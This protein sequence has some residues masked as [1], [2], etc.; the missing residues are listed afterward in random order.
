MMEHGLIILVLI[1]T[2]Y[3]GLK[4]RPWKQEFYLAGR[5]A[6]SVQ[7]A[8]SLL[9]TSLGG[10]AVFG[11][12]GK[13]SEIGWAAFWWLGGGAAGLLLLGLL[14]TTSMRRRPDNITLPQWLAAGYGEPAR[15]LS[16]VLIAIMWIGVV[17]AQWIAA[18]TLLNSLAG[19]PMAL[20]I[21]IMAFT[22]VIYTSAGGQSSVLRTDIL[23][24]LAIFGSL[25]LTAVFIIFQERL[26]ELIELFRVAAR[27]SEAEGNGQVVLTPFSWL[28]LMLVVGGMYVVG[29]DMYSRVVAARS[30]RQARRGALLA[31]AGLL[32]C[33]LL[34]TFL[35][36]FAGASGMEGEAG[37]QALA[38]LID[39]RLPFPL[40]SLLQAALLAALLSSADTCM[41]TAASVIN[42]DVLKKQGNDGSKKV[43]RTRL[44]V[45]VIGGAA[46]AVA[47]VS[48]R[49][50]GNI[51]M[52]Y[53]VYAGGLLVP[54]LLLRF[55]WRRVLR[56]GWVW[57]AMGLGGAVPLAA[58]IGGWFPS[59]DFMLSQA[60]AGMTGAL[61]SGVFCLIALV[62]GGRHGHRHTDGHGLTRTDTD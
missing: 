26:T 3:Y 52:A 34:L 47:M 41:L 45:A 21:S 37:D 54:L 17:S 59:P 40:S 16:A 18:G 46:A 51:M 23:Q 20:G 32:G 9:A 53:A 7:V 14:W 25:L 35:G 49:I 12:V 24:T 50:I 22:S 29:P 43:G 31:A 30:D 15:Y 28:S 56:P 8:G 13:A 62:A 39:R 5:Q 1:V 33:A 60:M 61:L 4:H 55:S 58:L 19:W 27:A 42:L 48:P 38:W 11:L 36:M 10:S 6:G 57:T 44:L 2:L